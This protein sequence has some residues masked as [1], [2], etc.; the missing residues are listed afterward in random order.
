MVEEAKTDFIA[1]MDGDDV[2]LPERFEE[3]M[4]EIAAHPDLAAL[5]TQRIEIDSNGKTLPDPPRMPS[6]FPDVLSKFLV[7]NAL[8]HPTVIFRR[9]AILAAGNYTPC[10]KP[11]EDFD[12]W[13]RVAKRNEIRNSNTPLLEY[14]VHDSGIISSARRAE[15]L[16]KPN[17]E[18]IRR[19]ASE[20]FGIAP[21]YYAKLRYKKTRFSFPFL[22]RAAKHIAVRANV[23]TARVLNSEYFLWS[24]R[25]LTAHKDIPSRA[26]WGLFDRLPNRRQCQI[27]YFLLSFQKL[28][29]AKLEKR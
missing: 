4:E 18:C 27:R 14:R 7:G 25:S 9:E 16:E 22:M 20:L 11:C 1:R 10:E 8:I 5:G 3:Q 21:E 23:P 24:A 28:L 29:I 15:T 2:C 26:L 19:H 12:L 17:T 6:E 13:L